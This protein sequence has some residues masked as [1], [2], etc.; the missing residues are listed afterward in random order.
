MNENKLPAC[1]AQLAATED[2]DECAACV[3]LKDFLDARGAAAPAFDRTAIEG[4]VSLLHD[5]AA[6][7]DGC[8]ILA[9]F[10]EGHCT[11][12]RQFRIGDVE[13]MAETIIEFDGH[14]NLNLYIP[15]AVMRRDLELGK[16]G[17]ESDVVAVLAAVADLDHD[18]YRLSELPLD[19]PYMVE[20]SKGNY[21]AVYPLARPL[22]VRD[23]KP[24]LT[25]LSNCIGGDCGTKDAS[26][27]W[28]I[29]GTLNWPVIIKKHF[30]GRFIESGELLSLAPPARPNG[31]SRGFELDILSQ[32]EEFKL[33]DALKYIPADDRDIWL[34]IGM[35]LHIAGARDL[36]DEWSKKSTKFDEAEQAK[37]WGSFHA[38][39]DGGTIRLGTLYHL[40]KEHGWK[41]PTDEAHKE[42][43]GVRL[44]D[45]CAYMRSL[46]YIFKPTG[47]FWPA[48]RVN[49]RI[50]PVPLFDKAGRPVLSDIPPY[51]QVHLRASKWLAE[52]APV[53]QM[54]WM[55]GLPQLIEHRLVSEGGWID[56]TD[57]HCFNL[58]RPPRIKPGDPDKAGKWIDHV[59]TIYPD[60]A[61]HI[62]RFLAHRVQRPQEKINH[63]LVLGGT[64]GIGKDTLLE[65][66]KYAV[67]PW[68]FVEVSP[69]QT[70]G[71]FNGF[72]KSV[73]LR[74]SEAKDMGDVDR[75]RLYDHLKAYTAAP[76]DVLRVDE[77]HLREHAV[78][79]VCGV[80]IT[81]NHKTD[82][83]YLPADD[84]RHFVAWS[85]L[86][87]EDFTEDYWIDLWASYER[88]GF[89]NVASYLALLDLSGFNPKAPPPKTPAFWAIVDASRAPE[90]AELADVLDSLENPDAVTLAMIIK[91]AAGEE[92]QEW[93]KDRKNRRVIPHR[94]EQCGYEPCAMT[95]PR[96][97]YSKSSVSGKSSTPEKT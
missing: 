27:V 79:N 32:T 67:G 2:A 95:A 73:I 15:W 41:P 19:A 68:N 30:D 59:R 5:L 40:A 66:V 80:I 18:K 64:Q 53:E 20:T 10:E 11:K 55:P 29:P 86:T 7:T 78:F 36:W 77:K 76:P 65:P 28:R 61:D 87:K 1:V 37:A 39:R 47:D 96:T 91:E 9:G 42:P 13:C 45:F 31:E 83:I 89:C 92:I 4:H 35:A 93:L 38:D 57:V 51:A 22:P 26:H 49:S 75:F 14:P 52:F 84:R 71:R 8:L 90:D 12:I 17:S 34:K 48:E 63:A 97:A 44:E 33:R 6:G 60:D 69:A 74:I 85:D 62:V 23:A 72:L 88:E 82:G 56:R 46:D 58:Y 81:T 25:A 50:P 24:A 70:L 21:Q 3:E 43:C 94:L 16:K 54:T